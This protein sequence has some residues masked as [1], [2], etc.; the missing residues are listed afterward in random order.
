M[1]NFRFSEEALSLAACKKRGMTAHN[2]AI[3]W[4]CES[5]LIGRPWDLIGRPWE[6]RYKQVL[7]L[8]DYLTKLSRTH[9]EIVDLLH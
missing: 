3:E 4:L 8:I 7:I 2:T 6:H 5:F 9:H 1:I